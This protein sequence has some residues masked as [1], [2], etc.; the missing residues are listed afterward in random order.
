M[1][2]ET[3]EHYIL[4]IPILL[5]SL[6]FHEFSHGY[7]AYRL[8]DITAKN[9][10]RLSLNPFKHLDPVGTLMMFFA[11][12]SSSKGQQYGGFADRDKCRLQGLLLF[13]QGL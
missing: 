10:G 12:H 13:R 7:V 4:M 3:L 6:T 11:G 2:N 9:A 1:F 5:I 8:G